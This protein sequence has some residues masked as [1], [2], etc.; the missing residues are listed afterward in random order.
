[1]SGVID[2]LTAHAQPLLPVTILTV[3]NLCLKIKVCM[4]EH[5]GPLASLANS[6]EALLFCVCDKN[7][8]R[9]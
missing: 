6:F 5:Q 8:F 2:I 4:C 1:M 7:P 3:Y 9:W